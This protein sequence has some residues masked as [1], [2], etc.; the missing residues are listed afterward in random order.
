MVQRGTFVTQA[1]VIAGAVL[2]GTAE[3]LFRPAGGQRV[4][5]AAVAGSWVG[6]GLAAVGRG[7]FVLGGRRGISKHW[8]GVRARIA[9]AIVAVLG[10]TL[11]VV[12]PRIQQ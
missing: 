9:G 5:L 12:I 3:W 1:M 11:F 6:V 7:D 4:F 2:G 8:R 10:L